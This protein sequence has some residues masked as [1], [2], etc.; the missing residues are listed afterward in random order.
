MSWGLAEA[1]VDELGALRS[2][3]KSYVAQ[4][5]DG[6]TRSISAELMLG[7]VAETPPLFLGTSWGLAEAA[8]DGLGV[9]RPGTAIAAIEIH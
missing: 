1:V 8:V 5:G 6:A 3:A 9:L 2:R 7:L 4:K